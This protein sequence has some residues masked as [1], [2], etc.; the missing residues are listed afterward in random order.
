MIQ[1]SDQEIDE[2]ISDSNLENI[3]AQEFSQ[4]IKSDHAPYMK[5]GMIEETSASALCSGIRVSGVV[6]DWVI[7]NASLPWWG[8][9]AVRTVKAI[10]NRLEDRIC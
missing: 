4:G 8:K 3:L 2:M 7:D 10:F 9:L 1:I 5:S 6:L